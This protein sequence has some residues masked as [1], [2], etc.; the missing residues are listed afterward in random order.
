MPVKITGLIPHNRSALGAPRPASEFDIEGM[1][2][3]AQVHDEAGFDRVLIAN[4]ASLPD[5]MAISQ[6]VTSNTKRLG[7]MVAHRPGFIA[8]TMAARML[9]TLDRFS[10]G[11]TGVHIIAGASDQELQADGDFSVK[12][13]RYRRAAEYVEIMRRTWSS[14]QPFDFDGEF[15]EVRGQ[16]ALIRPESG[17]LKVFWGGESDISIDLAGRH[18]DTY[19]IFGDTLAGT[20]ELVERAQAAAARHARALEMLMT[21]V[22]IVADTEGQAWDRAAAILERATAEKARS[23]VGDAKAAKNAVGRPAAL[24]MER[25]LKR[26]AE[27]ERLD[28]CLWTGMNKAME[29]R[30]NNTTLVGTA[31]Q[32]VDALL[33]YY[34][35]GVSGFLL[36]GYDMLPDAATLGRTVIPLLRQRVAELDASRASHD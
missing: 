23:T 36:R 33:A 15:Y 2:E 20:R 26:S 5:S 28:T 9:A 34:R 25:I 17:A 30:G 13:S 32:V 11:R 31:E 21:L 12:E 24:G 18:A 7:V 22:V 19:A 3:F 4:A 14:A 35:L 1:R 27:G 29:G 6:F 8:P 16:M 10:G